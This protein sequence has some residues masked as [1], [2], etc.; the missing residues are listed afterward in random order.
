MTRRNNFYFTVCC[1]TIIWIEYLN[2]LKIIRA[3]VFSYRK[4]CGFE[5]WRTNWQ[6]NSSFVM[7]LF[8]ELWKKP[9]AILNK[10]NQNSEVFF[11]PYFPSVKFINIYIYIMCKRK[12][13]SVTHLGFAVLWIISLSDTLYTVTYTMYANNI[14]AR[15]VFRWWSKYTTCIRVQTHFTVNRNWKCIF[16]FF[17]LPERINF[18]LNIIQEKLWIL[19]LCM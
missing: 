17:L 15:P 5:G 10:T 4:W 8:V 11:I 6:K 3:V 18:Q 7:Q 13:S 19:F 16:Y 9:K 1:N 14:Q 2:I 12:L